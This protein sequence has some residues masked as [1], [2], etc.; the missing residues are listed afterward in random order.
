MAADVGSLMAFGKDGGIA[1]DMPGFCK[2]NVAGSDFT[3]Q[4]ACVMFRLNVYEVVIADFVLAAIRN[5]KQ[6]YS[7]ITVVSDLDLC[8]KRTIDKFAD[9][10]FVTQR[11]DL[12]T[13]SANP[14]L[15]YAVNRLVEPDIGPTSET[16]PAHGKRGCVGA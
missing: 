8:A 16:A 9:K 7:R 12:K 1:E 2:Y 13:G 10:V 6:G 15:D 14:L 3:T 11:R 4:Q 5:A